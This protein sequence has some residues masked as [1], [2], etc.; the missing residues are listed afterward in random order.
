MI[1][2]RIKRSRRSAWRSTADAPPYRRPSRLAVSN[3][4]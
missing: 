1:A 3:F 4:K 2:A